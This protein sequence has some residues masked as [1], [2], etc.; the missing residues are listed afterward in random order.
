MGKNDLLYGI[1]LGLIYSQFFLPKKE[2]KTNLKF[3]TFY[4]IIFEG[5]ILLPINNK[6]VIHIHHWVIYLIATLFIENNT[7]L[8]FSIVLILQGLMYKDCFQFIEKKPIKYL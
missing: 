5:K 4:P 6:Q 7:F 2:G 3:L 1:L 8:G